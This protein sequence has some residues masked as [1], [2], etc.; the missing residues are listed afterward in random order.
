MYR[1]L[2]GYMPSVFSNDCF[3]SPFQLLEVLQ[4]ECGVDPS[5]TQDI[6][7]SSLTTSSSI[8]SID[9]M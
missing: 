7:V 2:R 5:V 9:S 4:H 3:F 6:S 1:N 8:T